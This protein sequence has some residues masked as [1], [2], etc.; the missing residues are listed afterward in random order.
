MLCVGRVIQKIVRDQAS[1]ILIVPWWPAKPW[2]GRLVPMNLR[3]LHFRARKGNLVP[4]G[5]PDNIE[6][7]NRVLL[8]P[9]FLAKKLRLPGFDKETILLLMNAWR[10]STK[11][12]STYLRKWAT[13][14]IEKGISILEPKLS[15][16]CRFLRLLSSQGL[17]YGAVNTA[18]LSYQPTKG[19]LLVPIR[20]YVG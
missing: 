12:Y 17:S 7:L 8:G 1:G 3:K 10:P 11:I 5:K 6:W 9:P 13:F 15:Q 2:W 16:V 19:I 20:I 14:C 4:Q 18:R